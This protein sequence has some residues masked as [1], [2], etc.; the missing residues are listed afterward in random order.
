MDVMTAF[1]IDLVGQKPPE[2]EVK[3][4]DFVWDKKWIIEMFSLIDHYRNLVPHV[5]YKLRLGNDIRRIGCPVGEMT[6]AK[7]VEIARRIYQLDEA[8]TFK[9]F[10]VGSDG[11][12]WRVITYTD[13]QRFLVAEESY[14]GRKKCISVRIELKE[15]P[16]H[17]P[18]TSS[19]DVDSS[20]IL[21]AFPEYQEDSGESED[22]EEASL[23]LCCAE[24]PQY[25]E[26]LE[27]PEI[28]H[29]TFKGF[30]TSHPRDQL[31]QDIK[32]CSES[33]CNLV[34]DVVGQQEKNGQKVDRLEE[35]LEGIRAT[36]AVV[37]NQLDLL[38]A[39]L[40]KVTK[41]PAMTKEEVNETIDAAVK[42][43]ISTI[44]KHAYQEI[45][46]LVEIEAI[47]LDTRTDID[48]V[49]SRIGKVHELHLNSIS[50]LM[51]SLAGLGE[52]MEAL[53]RKMGELKGSSVPSDTEEE[54]EEAAASGNVVTRERARSVPPSHARPAGRWKNPYLQKETTIPSRDYCRLMF[55]RLAF[56][57]GH[58]YRMHHVVGKVKTYFGHYPG[59]EEDLFSV[60]TLAS[61]I[62][63]YGVEEGLLIK[64]R[65]GHPGRETYTVAVV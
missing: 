46:K 33:M 48:A 12:E 36:M 6:W 38:S 45:S 9:F 29:T 47:A 28:A 61:A 50:L 62:L 19:E 22:E 37:V 2:E 8:D 54:S 59:D 35:Y 32:G 5:S 34:L 43:N 21:L 25:H 15:R 30:A 65:F 14:A 26:D 31:L 27:E 56:K 55:K 13:D 18:D 1:I 63:R 53:E 11:R 57:E 3:V 24:N 51:T 49:D 7:M 17:P 52:R 58:T 23:P 40:K 39:N 41:E 16:D 64:H 4:K 20:D 60:P 10:L 42:E 44:E